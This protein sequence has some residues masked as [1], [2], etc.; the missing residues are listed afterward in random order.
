MYESFVYPIRNSYTSYVT[1][2]DKENK[3]IDKE[4]KLLLSKI[5]SLEK[6]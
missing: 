2:I 1:D 3:E 5:N 4:N 6:T